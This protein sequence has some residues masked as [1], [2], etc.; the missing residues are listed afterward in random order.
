MGYCMYYL[1]RRLVGVSGFSVGDELGFRQSLSTLE[2]NR[3][4]STDTQ[5]AF[6][7]VDTPAEV[8][9]TDISILYYVTNN[10]DCFLSPKLYVSVQVIYIK[11]SRIN[12]K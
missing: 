7:S 10:I 2:S 1:T 9:T 12:V 5:G 3:R 8:S 11:T 4:R 6:N